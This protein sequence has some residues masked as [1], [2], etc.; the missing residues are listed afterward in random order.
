MKKSLITS[1]TSIFMVFMMSTMMAFANDTVNINMT[2]TEFLAKSN[3]EGVIT[4]SEDITLSDSLKVDA[5]NYTIDLNGHTLKF[6]KD[7]NLFVNNANVTFKNGTMNLDG[8]KGNADTI[9]GVGDYGSSAKLTLDKV[10]LQANN[11]TSPY[12]LIYVYNDSV[13][14]VENNSVLTA[15]NEK[16]LSGG[17]IKSSNGQAGKINITDSTLNFENAAR[18]FV[19]GTINIKN[20][21]VNMKGL[22]NGINSSTGGLNLTVDNSKLTITGSIGRALTLDGTT[23]SFKNNSVIDFSNSLVSDI[24]FKSQGKIEVDKSSELNFKKVKLDEAVKGTELNDLI[25]SENYEYQLD[26]KG[27]VTITQKP[28]DVEQPGDTEQPGDVENPSDTNNGGITTTPGTEND[29]TTTDKLPVTGVEKLAYLFVGIVTITVGGLVW[30][31]S[32]SRKLR[33]K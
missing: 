27:N 25:I 21:T 12:A 9:L 23:V 8:I 4:L 28:G 26:D 32:E 24:M 11:Y 22:S 17:V 19:D 1:L 31:T 30:F 16:S 7:T 5:K 15:K 10:E 18:G 6:T 29:T 33:R 14:N 3:V 13:L 20:S 2:S